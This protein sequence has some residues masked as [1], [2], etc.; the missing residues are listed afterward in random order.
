MVV[1][2]AAFAILLGRLVQIQV[3]EAASYKELARRQHSRSVPLPAT[4]GYLFDRRGNL[5]VS[6]SPDLSYG[7]DP[8]M[9]GDQAQALARRFAMVFDRPASTYLS[10]LRK[11]DRRFVWLE[12]RVSPSV[13][14]RIQA[15]SFQGL[16]EQTEP[17]RVYHFGSIT[18]TVIGF[19]NIDNRGT[20]RTGA[21]LR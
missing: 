17:R 13:S 2:L 20:G 1:F 7:A 14:S 5:L 4:R 10:L 19:T 21:G 18:S 6:N 11:K 12:R 3:L 8:V 15:S 16:V 9:V